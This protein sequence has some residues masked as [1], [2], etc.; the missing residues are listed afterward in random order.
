[1]QT[2]PVTLAT[3]IRPAHG[4]RFN[5]CQGQTVMQPHAVNAS[6]HSPPWFRLVLLGCLSAGLYFVLFTHQSE[7]I[8]LARSG[9]WQALVIILIT[10]LFSFAHGQFTSDFWEVLGVRANKP[11]APKERTTTDLSSD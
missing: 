4:L 7:V 5:H 2:Q 1:M 10:F 8:G 6:P 11:D 9:R 3:N